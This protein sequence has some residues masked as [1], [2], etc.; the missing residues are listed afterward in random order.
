M[1]TAY[2]KVF[3]GDDSMETVKVSDL[4]KVYNEK[5]MPVDA[6]RGVDLSVEKGEF[7]ALVG[8]SGSG[9][10]TLLNLVGGLDRPTEGEIFIEGRAITGLL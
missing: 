1:L 10:T 8:P 9:K 5:G 2:L 3:S 4:R 7:L 6:L